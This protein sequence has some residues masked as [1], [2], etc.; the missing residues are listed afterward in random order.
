[1]H[2]TVFEICCKHLL[3][4]RALHNKGNAAAGLRDESLR[5]VR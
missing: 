3:L 5:T 1:M 2:Y 4:Y